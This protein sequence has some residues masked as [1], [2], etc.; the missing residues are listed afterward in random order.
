MNPIVRL[1]GGDDAGGEQLPADKR[2]AL[3]AYLAYDGGWLNRE[4]L[5]FLFWPD[6]DEAGARRNLRQLL[7]RV[8]ALHLSVPPEIETQRLRWTVPTD[9]AAFRQAYA[10]QTWAE[11]IALYRGELLQGFPL[12]GASGFGAW[13]ELERENL[14]QAYRRAVERAAEAL[15]EAGDHAAAAEL[16]TPLLNGEELAEEAL[17]AYMRNAYLAG[18]RDHALAAYRRFAARLEDELALEPLD[19]TRELAD[20]ITRAAPVTGLAPAPA[21]AVRTPLTV[22]RPPRVVGREAEARQARTAATPVVLLRGEAGVG[23][24]RLMEELAPGAAARTVRCLEGLRSVPYQPIVEL[25]R[26]SMTAGLDLSSL[27]DYRDDLARLLPEALPAQRPPP[28]DPATAKA[29]LLEALARF[30][31]LAF[32]GAEGRFDLL[33]DDLQWADDGTLELL[34]FL[35]SRR[36]LRLLGAF[37][38]FEEGPRLSATLAALRSD[39]ALTVVELEPLGEPELRR[40]LAELIG[41]DEGPA[42]FSQWLHKSSAGNVMFAL[43]TLKSLFE[44]GVLR[45]GEA[46]WSTE[47]DAITRDYSELETPRA[48]AE[49]VERRA[50]RL[51]SEAL[52]AVQAAA[53]MGQDLDPAT[54][55]RAVGLSEWAALDAF[56]ELERSG[57]LAGNAFRHDLLRQ[58]VYRNLPQAR[59]RLLHGR[60]AQVLDAG[61][62]PIVVSEHLLAAGEFG[63]AASL[64]LGA[65]SELERLGLTEQATALLETSIATIERESPGH[66]ALLRLRAGLAGA[67]RTAGHAERSLAQAEAVLAEATDPYLLASALETKAG[68]QL[69]SGQLEEALG[70]AQRAQELAE[71]VGAERLARSASVLVASVAYYQGRFDDALEIVKRNVEALRA[72]GTDIDLASQL[73]SLG[74]IHDDLGR[75][76]EALGAHQEAL[77]IAQRLR[78]KFV[79]VNVAMNLLQCLMALGRPEEALGVAREALALGRFDS[80]ATLRNN[81]AASLMDLGRLDEAEAE[82][83]V[84]LEEVS[85]PTL[86]ALALARLARIHHARGRHAQAREALEQALEQARLTDY[87]VARVSVARS[88]VDVGD[89]ALQRELPDLLL[90]LDDKSLPPELRPT[91]ATDAPDAEAPDTG[92]PDAGTPDAATPDARAPGA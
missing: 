63:R 80:T 16:L 58:S 84:Q 35:A 57:M 34:S 6:T 42:A 71:R 64:Q 85:D 89:E 2:G 82:F 8:R 44:A 73:T 90:G 19:A 68:L 67:Y 87:P 78:S 3:L 79:Q 65:I 40:L 61:E 7:N 41:V 23:K 31:E 5:A 39:H 13:L 56:D 29:R 55:A 91:P 48:I 1:L 92:T 88:L 22:Q 11:V 25:A 37:R 49:V 17:Q 81:F 46:G 54:V 14:R 30:L 53:V 10:R 18:Q 38:R 9:V 24:S 52:R 43:E 32:Q 74:A 60:V 4:R 20:T 15:E 50:G 59:R 69:G 72:D 51:S 66:E 45:L 28:A 77:G 26:G 83:A 27:G 62:Q 70:T 33:F 21:P 36:R 75:H 12:D 86:R 47:L 76:E